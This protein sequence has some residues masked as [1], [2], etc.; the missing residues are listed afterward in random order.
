MTDRVARSKSANAL[1]EARPCGTPTR[2]AQSAHDP[3]HPAAAVDL[4]L[5][6]APLP[7]AEGVLAAA[8][9]PAAAAGLHSPRVAGPPRACRCLAY[10]GPTTVDSSRSDSAASSATVR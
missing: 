10:P 5:R 7:P 9:G 3:I 4:D 6:E 8:D 1:P 2:R